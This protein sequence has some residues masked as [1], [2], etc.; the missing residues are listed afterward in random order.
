[1]YDDL[2]RSGSVDTM[3][4][5][6][7]HEN[8]SIAIQMIQI[9]CELFDP[10]NSCGV[11]A[12]KKLA[13][14]FIKEGLSSQ[15]KDFFMA[16]EHEKYEGY[17]DA[18]SLVLAILKIDVNYGLQLLDDTNIISWSSERLINADEKDDENKV[19][20]SAKYEFAE[21]LA[22]IFILEPQTILRFSDKEIEMLLIELSAL[23]TTIPRPSSDEEGYFKDIF[24]IFMSSI[25]FPWVNQGF[26]NNEGV[27]L[28]LMLLSLKEQE[29]WVKKNVLKVLSESA[30]GY[31]GINKDVCITL[32]ESGGI[33]TIFSFLKK[34]SLVSFLF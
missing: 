34:V 12:M 31:G 8:I 5:M 17:S 28:F 14:A 16:S 4:S 29:T 24:D 30:R 27:E 15:L 25:K 13:G 33:K 2:R 32:V 11:D 6:L 21:F 20:D 10:E 9:M 22:E 18:L 23:R 7:T 3:L 1:M 26:L 19:P